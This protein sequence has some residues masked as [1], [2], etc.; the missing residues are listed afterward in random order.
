MA[1]AFCLEIALEGG[2]EINA[3]FKLL[4]SE[5]KLVDACFAKTKIPPRNSGL[6]PILCVFIGLIPKIE[7]PADSY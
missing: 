4:G 2:R 1:E 7:V 6:M 5:M 3:S